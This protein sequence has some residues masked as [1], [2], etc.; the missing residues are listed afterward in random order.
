MSV[1]TLKNFTRTLTAN[2]TIRIDYPGSIIKCT[3]GSAIFEVRP[4]NGNRVELQQGLG[5]KFTGDLV[6]QWQ[7]INGATAQTITLYIATGE[8]TDDRLLGAINVSANTSS[9]YANVTVAVTATVILAA[10]TSRANLL[11]QNLGGANLY[12]GNDSSVTTANGIE[13]P[14]NGTITL[15]VDDDIYGISASGNLDVRYFEEVI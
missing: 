11:I 7:I 14:P 5:V 6:T 10:N 9:N 4:D 1:I 12:I 2:E 8:I 13:I 3:S 15:T